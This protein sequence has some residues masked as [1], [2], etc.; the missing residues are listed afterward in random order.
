MREA[1]SQNEVFV[2]LVGFLRKS[3]KHVRR[4]CVL[5]CSCY[6]EVVV[7][8]LETNAKGVHRLPT[9]EVPVNVTWPFRECP[10]AWGEPE[11]KLMWQ[12]EIAMWEVNV[13]DVWSLFLTGNCLPQLKDVGGNELIWKLL[14]WT[15]PAR[16]NHL[17]WILSMLQHS[18][19]LLALW[20]TVH[21]NTH[22]WS[23]MLD[24]TPGKSN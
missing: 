5:K 13:C 14:L 11:W 16:C 19:S 21:L 1:T 23:R 12:N 24:Q 20:L 2:Y 3:S 10:F 4:D 15:L 17:T 7:L 9:W 6:L 22:K 18:Q 8:F